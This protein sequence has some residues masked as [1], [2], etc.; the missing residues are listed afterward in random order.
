MTGT[1]RSSIVGAGAQW[2]APLSAGVGALWARPVLAHAAPCA[3]APLHWRRDLALLHAECRALP[4]CVY[5]YDL[6]TAAALSIP[7]SHGYPVRN[8]LTA[9]ILKAA[10]DCTMDSYALSVF[11]LIVFRTCTYKPL[12]SVH[13]QLSSR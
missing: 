13:A 10:A 3:P 8:L 4:H 2:A 1:A 5:R 7:V 6:R 11:I 12:K 9:Y